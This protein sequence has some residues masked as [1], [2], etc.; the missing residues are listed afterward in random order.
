MIEIFKGI[1]LLAINVFNQVFFVEIELTPE[2]SL[3]FGVCLIAIVLLIII[4]VIVLRIF[5]IDI[6][7]DDE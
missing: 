4:I 5:N 6:G 7:G 3:P 2:L 1:I